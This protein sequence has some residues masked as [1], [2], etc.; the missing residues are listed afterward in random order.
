MNYLSVWGKSCGI[1]EFKILNNV[2]HNRDDPRV[3]LSICPYRTVTFKCSMC[4][5][6]SSTSRKPAYG[7]MIRYNCSINDQVII[8]KSILFPKTCI[9]YHASF[10]QVGSNVGVQII[11]KA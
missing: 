6:A 2:R 1:T 7:V 10:K 4:P 9:H 8:L 3:K 11:K 5:N